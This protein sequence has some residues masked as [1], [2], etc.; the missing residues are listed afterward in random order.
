MK[1]ERLLVVACVVFLAGCAGLGGAGK[2][3]LLVHSYHKG[4]AWTDDITAGVYEG[5]QGTGAR[6]D[7]YYMDTKRQTATEWKQKAGAMAMQHVDELKPPLVIAADDN[8]Q[9][10][11]AKG[12]AGKDSPQI[13][14]C[15]VNA[16]A[17]AYGYP[18]ENVTGVL[19]RAANVATLNLLKR[20]APGVKTIAVIC[21]DSPTGA[22]MIAQMK[23]AEAQLPVK[24]VAYEQPATFDAWKAAVQ[25]LRT[26]ADAL[27]ITLY[28][29]VKRTPGGPRVPPKEVVGWTVAN[30]D[31]PSVTS[32]TYGVEDGVLCGV[33]ESGVEHG[34]LAADMARRILQGKKAGEMPIVVAQEG[35]VQVNLKTAARLG[36]QVSPGLLKEADKVIR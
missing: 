23:A 28:M 31:K 24:V 11:F 27:H 20:I 26:R 6:L 9:A 10:Y 18:A 33:V 2:S 36:L 35:M 29:T 16:R 34:V 14:F 7:V 22:G 13:V 30:W 32:Y 5:L 25:K 12:Y 8:A 17:E 3:V 15:G 1:V 21:D 19:E 4:Y